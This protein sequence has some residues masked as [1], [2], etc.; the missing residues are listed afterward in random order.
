MQNR[1]GLVKPASAGLH[2][3]YNWGRGA[4]IKMRG[5]MHSRRLNF[6]TFLNAATKHNS[7][8]SRSYDYAWGCII[9]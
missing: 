1:H 2:G 5:A 7:L 8:D 9:L 3:V 6:Y 4:P